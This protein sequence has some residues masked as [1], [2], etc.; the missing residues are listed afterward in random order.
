MTARR[1]GLEWRDR[2][3]TAVELEVG[4]DG[5]SVVGSV[6][7]S[8]PPDVPVTPDSVRAALSEGGVGPGRAVLALSGRD[9]SVK[10]LWLPPLPDPPLLS[11]LREEGDRYFLLPEEPRCYGLFPAGRQG[12]EGEPPDG[13]R[14]RWAVA[15]PASEVA[16]LLDVLEEAGVH[17]SR[18]TASA[19]LDPS[20]GAGTARAVP[21]GGADA[22]D[23][24]AAAAGVRPDPGLPAAGT[25]AGAL[26]AALS[27]PTSDAG[28]DLVP[29]QV[30]RARRRRSRRTTAAL[31]AAVAV[32][33]ALAAWLGDRRGE[34]REAM[35][36]AQLR[37]ARAAAAPV[38]ER[39]EA[40]ARVARQVSA[41]REATERRPSHLRLLTSVTGALPG[42]AWIASYVSRDDRREA[43]LT[44]YAPS[45][46]AALAH[47]ADLPGVEAARFERPTRKVDVADATFESFTVS[48]TLRPA[49]A[50]RPAAE[51]PGDGEAPSPATGG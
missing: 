7:R 48:L 29:M 13:E 22:A 30:R 8:W 39:K 27:D 21:E 31:A 37:E 17:V 15:A 23:R 9:V 6:R 46:T 14:A 38:I 40:V 42:E 50:D 26:A 20:R 5:P 43:L 19:A 1:L 51:R 34:R 11:M 36:E 3:L 25:F 18:V 10:P 16:G 12:G 24:G 44:G 28:P 45:A 2:T 41:F 32:L 47:L 4:A 35:V 49:P 33:L